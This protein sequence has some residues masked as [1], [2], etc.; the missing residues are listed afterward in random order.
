MKSMQSQITACKSQTSP[1]HQRI[2]KTQPH[3]V[4]IPNKAILTSETCPTFQRTDVHEHND[5]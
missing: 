5:L 1:D 4:S 2:K 3:K